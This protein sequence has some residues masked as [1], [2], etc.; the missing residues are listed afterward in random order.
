MPSSIPFWIDWA[1]ISNKKEVSNF[2]LKTEDE[3]NTSRFGNT[4]IKEVYTGT[5]EAQAI[6]V[7]E[8]DLLDFYII[9][10]RTKGTGIKVYTHG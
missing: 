5:D 1:I 7:S 4:E 10:E 9:L 6:L 3:A 2:F 8:H